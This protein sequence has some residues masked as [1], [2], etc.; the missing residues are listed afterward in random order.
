MRE[1]LAEQLLGITLEW[2]TH[3]AKEEIGKLRYLAAVKYD[4]YQ[5]FEPGNRFL[6]S[7]VL[8]L[9]QFRTTK[10]RLI[11]YRFL[12][13]RLVYISEA[14][15]DH[16]VGLLYPQRILP[17]LLEQVVEREDIPSHYIKKIRA[18]ETF[19]VLRRK[20]IFLGLSDGARMDSFRRKNTLSNDQ[21]SVSYE[22]SDKKWKRMHDD[23]E[24]WIQ[25]IGAKT[26]PLF[27]NIFLIDDFSGSGNS[28]LRPDKE[29]YAGKL[30]KFVE[31]QLG[32][33]ETPGPLGKWCI[34]GGPRLFVVTYLSTRQALSELKT[35]KES[36]LKTLARPNIASCEI[37]EPL[38]IFED[39]LKVPQSENENDKCFDVL[40]E[41]Y[42][43][44]RIEDENTRTGG[45]DV[46]HGYSGCGLPLVLCHNCP[47]NSVYLLWAQTDKSETTP[48]L[49]P[50]F[51]RI[52]RH[53]EGR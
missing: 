52:S 14:Q 34:K 23:L 50:L 1:D 42:Y 28:I 20:S 35:R 12:S 29:S 25:K 40:L 13:S 5:N 43:D 17:V 46:K 53:A 41:D 44:N 9:R 30:I 16:L 2:E 21:I 19:G 37:M 22:L 32:T 48:G 24:K 39:G 15:M 47:N 10:E 45:K 26:E 31:E 38:Q 27:E 51:R 49:R 8:W 33:I 3:T 36:L 4:S 6:E 18:A 11:A 7:L